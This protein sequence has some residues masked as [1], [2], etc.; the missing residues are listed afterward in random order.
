MFKKKIFALLAVGVMTFAFASSALAGFENDGR[1]FHNDFNGF[2]PF[3]HAGFN[4][5]FF[6]NNR[7]FDDRFFFDDKFDDDNFFGEFDD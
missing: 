7:F 4:D 6:D 5:N 2:N 1:F 3:F